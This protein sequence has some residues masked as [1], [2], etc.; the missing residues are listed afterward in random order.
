MLGLSKPVTMS[1]KTF[2]EMWQYVDSVYAK[3]H[4]E[5]LQVAIDGTVGMRSE[6]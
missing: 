2:D 1:P 4:Q 5:L 6:I 3:L